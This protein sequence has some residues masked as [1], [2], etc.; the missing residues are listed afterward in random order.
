MNKIETVLDNIKNRR[1]LKPA[2]YTGE[3]LADTAV[4]TILETANW[5]PTHG[6]TEPW[7]FVVYSGAGKEKLLDFMTYLSD[8]T[9][10][11]QVRFEKRKALYDNASH[12][13][14]IG[15]KRGANPAIPEVEEILSV[16]CAVQNMWLTAAAMG[17][18]AYWSTGA[19]ALRSEL[20][21]FMGLDPETDKAFGFLFLGVPAKANP[22]GRR[23]SGIEE[24]VSF[25][26]A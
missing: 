15:M 2:D 8:G 7:R 1:T 5:A 25:V 22:Q 4:Q 6:Y 3:M 19:D 18:G 14:A 20:A 16:G 10:I 24:K 11:N 17:I 23:I 9:E 21:Q 26:S 13:I 12:I